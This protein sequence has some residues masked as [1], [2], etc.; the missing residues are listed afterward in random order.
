MNKNIVKIIGMAMA[1][2][3]TSLTAPLVSQASIFDDPAVCETTPF[4][5]ATDILILHKLTLDNEAIFV[6]SP[7]AGDIAA[8]LA[9]KLYEDRSAFGQPDRG[10]APKVLKGKY[11][12]AISQLQAYVTGLDKAKGRFFFILAI[13]P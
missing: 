13:L 6:S 8:K 1:C 11:P 5:V 9:M 2:A 7:K 4:D 10:A 3:L 12:D